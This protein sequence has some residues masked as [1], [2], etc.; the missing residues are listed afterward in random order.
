M[1]PRPFP[2]RQ[3]HKG[4][5][6]VLWWIFLWP[7]GTFT[8]HLL[9]AGNRAECI[10]L[11][12]RG[13][14]K[15]RPHMHAKSLQSCLTLVTPWT[16]ACQTPLCPW[17]SP[18]KNTG[19]DCHAQWLKE[20]AWTTELRHVDSHTEKSYPVSGSL[21]CSQLHQGETSGHTKLSHAPL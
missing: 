17:D 11:P 20:S 1:I 19:V 13:T 3:V 5:C 15:G 12:P 8:E 16:G 9:W 14:S 4:M 10:M 6:S 21:S 18:K 2:S 7:V